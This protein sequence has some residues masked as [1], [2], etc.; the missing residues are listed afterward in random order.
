MVLGQI[1]TLQRFGWLANFAVSISRRYKYLLRNANVPQVWTTVVWY[2]H[3]ALRL[4][5]ESV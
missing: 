5:R 3:P 1:R 2:D 4:T